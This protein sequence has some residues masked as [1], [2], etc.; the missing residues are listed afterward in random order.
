MGR[1]TRLVARALRVLRTTVARHHQ[2]GLRRGYDVPM[3]GRPHF[4]EIVTPDVDA[5]VLQYTEAVDARFSDPVVELGG[6]RVAELPGG[7]EHGLW[8][9]P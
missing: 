3:N 8:Q 1:S 4:L 5:V 9:R 2:A 7:V 6:A